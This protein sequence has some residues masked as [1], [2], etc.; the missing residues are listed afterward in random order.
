MP[1]VRP[2][3]WAVAP[4]LV[5]WLL[6]SWWSSTHP[7]ALVPARRLGVSHARCSRRE[8]RASSNRKMGAGECR[9]TGRR[10]ALAAF[11]GGVP[12][13]SGFPPPSSSSAEQPLR[14][15]LRAERIKCE[16]IA[17]A[18]GTR[19]PCARLYRPQRGAVWLAFFVEGATFQRFV[20]TS[21]EVRELPLLP[22]AALEGL[23]VQLRDELEFGALADPRRLWR[24][25]RKA[26]TALLAPAARELAKAH[27]LVLLPDGLL[28]FL[29]FHALVLPQA[30]SPSA[31]A[32]PGP[33]KAQPRFAIERWEIAYLPSAAFA[34]SVH[35][36]PFVLRSATL[37]LPSYGMPPRPLAGAAAEI[38]AITLRL[39]TVGLPTTPLRDESATPHAMVRALAVPAGLV[40]FAGHGHV[41]LW[42]TR[43]P[44]LLW[45]DSERSLRLDHLRGRRLEA[46]LVVLAGCTTAYAALFRNDRRLGVRH[47]FPDALLGAGVG[48]VV[49]A[50]WAVKDHQSQAQMA[51]FYR[52]LSRGPR[53]ALA[54]AQRE[55]LRRLRPPHPR[56]WAFYALYGAPG[57]AL[58]CGK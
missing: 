31:A 36:E 33:A 58:A 48:S 38:E 44:E 14:R 6:V 29:P 23:V 12:T 17:G 42:H 55:R 18:L 56:F 35:E 39:R 53:R 27:A 45:A 32:P 49:A 41:D 24:L 21:D 13:G 30:L 51:S 47:S 4:L 10:P 40:H 2:S 16:R 7:V 20:V 34:H 11:R 5:L 43:R 26:F 8:S 50:S 25:S 19:A 46:G 3:R 9:E 57:L 52:H 37:V 22:R 54:L 1:L 28:R 15:W